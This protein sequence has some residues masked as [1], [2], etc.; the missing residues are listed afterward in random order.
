MFLTME[1]RVQQLTQQ[2]FNYKQ[3]VSKNYILL[4]FLELFKGYNESEFQY[5]KSWDWL[6][7]ILKKIAEKDD[8]FRTRVTSIMSEYNYDIEQIWKFTVK[9]IELSSM[10]DQGYH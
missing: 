9:H 2:L 1:Q 5:H 8:I 6:I 7:P 10:S 4:Y 3:K